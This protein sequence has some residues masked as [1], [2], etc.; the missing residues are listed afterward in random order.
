MA[1]PRMASGATR[2]A[3]IPRVS[4]ILLPRRLDRREGRSGKS[5]RQVCAGR[6][7]A[8]GSRL[9]DRACSSCGPARGE[10]C[11]HERAAVSLVSRVLIAFVTSQGEGARPW[12]CGSAVVARSPGSPFLRCGA[13]AKRMRARCFMNVIVDAS[14][15]GRRTGLTSVPQ[16]GCVRGIGAVSVCDDRSRSR[17][18]AV[19]LDVDGC[20]GVRGDCGGTTRAP[21]S[22]GVSRQD[23]G[24]Q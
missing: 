10:L 22:T 9:R 15:S 19:S 23:R 21:G 18:G 5:R 13:D 8:A 7:P 1:S 2:S 14:S 6:A 4:R 17:L 3:S 24:S 12:D 11:C 16:G 20:R